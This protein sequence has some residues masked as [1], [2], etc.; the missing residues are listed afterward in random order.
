MQRTLL[1]E[2]RMPYW[3][4]RLTLETESQP[5]FAACF[6]SWCD[7]FQYLKEKLSRADPEEENIDKNIKSKSDL[8]EGYFLDTTYGVRVPSLNGYNS[9]RH[10]QWGVARGILPSRAGNKRCAWPRIRL[11]LAW[12]RNHEA[13]CWLRLR[14]VEFTS[15]AKFAVSGS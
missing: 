4:P 15:G 1:M 3:D 8:A 11:L 10:K 12:S 14:M 2:Q 7:H 9:L 13:G 6:C 5:R